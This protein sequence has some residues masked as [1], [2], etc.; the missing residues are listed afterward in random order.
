MIPDKVNGTK[1]S[2][3]AKAEVLFK[4]EDLRESVE[5]AY[6]G[7]VERTRAVVDGLGN[8][9]TAGFQE[10]TDIVQKCERRVTLLATSLGQRAQVLM[11]T[12]SAL[13]FQHLGLSHLA[14]EM[15]LSLDKEPGAEERY[16]EIFAR[17]FEIARE[18]YVAEEK[19]LQEEAQARDQAATPDAQP[20]PI[21]FGGD[22]SREVK[23]ASNQE[24]SEVNA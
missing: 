20:E 4:L 10:L 21:M 17:S 3:S 14:R 1:L 8:R 12:Q 5:K 2:T 7:V 19:R 6:N 23:L 13:N 22:A 15:Y 11:A 9:A 16:K 18:E 24:V